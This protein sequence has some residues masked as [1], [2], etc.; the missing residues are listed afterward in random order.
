MGI[1]APKLRASARG[2]ACTFQT[3]FC[4]GDPDTTVLCHA[5]SEFKGGGTKGHDFHAAFGCSA[6]HD[7]LD[8]HKLPNEHELFYW[9]RGC[10]RTL[11]EW[12]LTGL[13][14]VPV[15]VATAKRRPK[16]RANLPSRPLRSRGFP[17]RVALTL[18]GDEHD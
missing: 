14:I 11:T 12:V 1:I 17:K 10:Q 13:V 18:S 15:D 3:P 9:L 16:K 6:C 8:Q 5:P 7:A 4:N 2:K